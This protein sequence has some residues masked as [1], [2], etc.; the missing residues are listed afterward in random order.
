[1]DKSDVEEIKE[2]LEE[3]LKLTSIEDDSFVHLSLR[4]ALLHANIY[5][6]REDEREKE[7]NS[8]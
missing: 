5:I 4:M 7:S 8:T 1:M 6:E 2:K 3:C